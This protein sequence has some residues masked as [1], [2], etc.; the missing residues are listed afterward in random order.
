[1]LMSRDG[2]SLSKEIKEPSHAEG[3][4]SEQGGCDSEQEA[5][6]GHNLLCFGPI[7]K[8]LFIKDQYR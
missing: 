2:T 7:P 6:P 3:E 5:S 1:M 4:E 8:R